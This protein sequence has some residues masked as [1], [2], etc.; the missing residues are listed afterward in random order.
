MARPKIADEKKRVRLSTTV[1]PETIEYLKNEKGEHI[2]IGVFIDTIV[3]N[4]TNKNF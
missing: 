2:S 1:S 4:H 3:R